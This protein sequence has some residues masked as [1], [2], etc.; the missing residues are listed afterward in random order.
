MFRSTVKEALAGV[1]AGTTA[2][3]WTQFCDVVPRVGE[4]TGC[5]FSPSG[6]E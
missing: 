3:R 2:T 5:D 6:Y 4:Q 1:A